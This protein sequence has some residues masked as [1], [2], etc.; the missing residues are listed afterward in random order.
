LGI[1]DG[2]VGMT[3]MGFAGWT[4]E[5]HGRVGVGWTRL[6]FGGCRWGVHGEKLRGHS[7]RSVLGGSAVSGWLPGLRVEVSACRGAWLRANAALWDAVSGLPGAVSRGCRGR[8]LR[9]GAAGK[10]GS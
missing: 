1:L 3:G 7:P 5:G 10:W 9:I 6:L 4:G 8:L 2:G